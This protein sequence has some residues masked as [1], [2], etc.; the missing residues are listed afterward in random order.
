[1]ASSLQ[2]SNASD[3]LFV[4][5]VESGQLSAESLARARRLAAELG[6]TVPATLTRLGFVSERDMAQAFA[7]AVYTE[8]LIRLMT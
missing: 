8:N 4:A 2:V 1:M 5:L 6:E 3:L 7:T